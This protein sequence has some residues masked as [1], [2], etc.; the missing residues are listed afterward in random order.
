MRFRSSRPARLR[1]PLGVA[2]LLAGCGTNHVIIG[3]DIASF[4]AEDLRAAAYGAPAPL[5]PATPVSVP[6]L[7]ETVATPKGLDEIAEVQEA[8]LEIR[9]VFDNGS[10]RASGT[11]EVLLAAEGENPYD[12]APAAVLPVALRA[13]E[14]TT[15]ARTVPIDEAYHDL[16]LAGTFEVGIRIRLETEGVDPVYGSYEIQVLRAHVVTDPSLGG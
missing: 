3:V 14:V 15:A 5:P 7:A 6:I 9:V 12:G 11:F 10:G 16:F 4:F 13:G 2:V 1:F 8:D